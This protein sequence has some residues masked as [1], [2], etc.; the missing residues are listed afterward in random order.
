MPLL[1][2]NDFPPGGFPYREPSLNWVAP[3]DGAP[4]GLRVQQIQAVRIANPSAG[5]NPTKEACEDALDLYTCTRLGNDPA[6]CVA[7]ADPVAK[8]LAAARK[9]PRCG[10]CGQRRERS[11]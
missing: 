2:R 8:A 11:K 1:N 6:W 5:L 7:P 10:G 3:R 9:P 4:F